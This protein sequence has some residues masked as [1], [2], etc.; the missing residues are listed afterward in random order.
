MVGRA[1]GGVLTFSLRRA[2]DSCPRVSIRCNI[3]HRPRDNTP[4]RIFHQLPVEVSAELQDAHLRS[5]GETKDTVC[6][7]DLFVGFGL[8]GCFPDLRK[9][10][11]N[12]FQ[13]GNEAPLSTTHNL[14][15]HFI[16]DLGWDGFAYSNKRA[17]FENVCVHLLKN[18]SSVQR[19]FAACLIFFTLGPI[20][21]QNLTSL[22]SLD[23]FRDTYDSV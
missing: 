22:P 21:A 13:H 2:S 23:S 8:V 14:S 4:K 1:Y 6:G 20:S 19:C 15:F 11:E 5:F 17:A 18:P 9:E 7:L 10:R 3:A 16:V 12:I